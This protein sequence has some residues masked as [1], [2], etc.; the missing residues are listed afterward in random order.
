MCIQKTTRK[1]EAFHFF[2]NPNIC[3]SDL[4]IMAQQ[5]PTIYISEN[6]CVCRVHPEVNLPNLYQYLEVMC[7]FNRITK[8]H[9][10]FYWYTDYTPENTTTEMT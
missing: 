7:Y 4:G 10:D 6:M 3:V 8:N 9:G 2:I 1:N 5:V